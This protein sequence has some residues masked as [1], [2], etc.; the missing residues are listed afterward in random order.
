M[1]PQQVLL[2]CNDKAFQSRRSFVDLV[3]EELGTWY[4]FERLGTYLTPADLGARPPSLGWT[5]DIRDPFYAEPVVL[6]GWS[7]VC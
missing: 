2:M 6:A 3:E 7:H 1:R 4:R 5:A